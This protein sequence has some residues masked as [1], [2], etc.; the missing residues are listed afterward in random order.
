MFIL[1]IEVDNEA[2]QEDKRG[3]IARIL[4]DIADKIRQ[5]KEPSKPIDYNGNSCGSID[6]NI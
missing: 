2:F 3:E 5:G 4:E 1:K 6:W